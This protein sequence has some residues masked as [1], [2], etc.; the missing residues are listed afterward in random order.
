[1]NRQSKWY[2]AASTAHELEAGS[3]TAAQWLRTSLHLDHDLW[4]FIERNL[5]VKQRCPGPHTEPSA[6]GRQWLDLTPLR[7]DRPANMGNQN[8][9]RRVVKP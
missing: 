9:E 4:V 1:M 2:L 6:L 7:L 5:C 3:W 8:H